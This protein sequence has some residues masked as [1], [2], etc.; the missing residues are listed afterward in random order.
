VRCPFCKEDKDRVVDSRSS[1]D[2][3]AIRRRRECLACKRR[4]TTYETVEEGAMR[5][6]KK[7]GSRETYDRNKLLVSLRKACE[8][9]PVSTQALEV[10]ADD[11]EKAIHAT[12][13]REVSSRFIGEEVMRQLRN[14]DHVAYVR[15]ASVYRDFKE[16]GEFVREIEKLRQEECG[17]QHG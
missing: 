17:A 16:V 7:D 8:K 15:F 3:T 13:D 10:A 4:Y 1:G 2:A 5:V 9:R 12:F 14:V 6:E 11:V